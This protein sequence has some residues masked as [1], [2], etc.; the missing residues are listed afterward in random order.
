M[1]VPGVNLICAATFLAA[2]GEHPP[3]HDQPQAGRLSRAWIRRSASP[4]RRRHAPGGSPSAGRRTRGGRWS[5]RRGAWSGNPGRCTRSTSGPARGA[6]TARRSSRPPASSRSCS[7]ACSPAARTTP[8]SS[9][10]LTKKKLREL[11]LTAGAEAARPRPPPGSGRPTG[12]PRR[13]ARTRRASRGRPTS[14]WSTTSRPER[15][16]E[17]WAR[18][19]HRSAHKLGPR[20]AKLRGRLKAPDVC[21]SLRQS[22]APTDNLTRHDNADNPGDDHLLRKYRPQPR[23]SRPTRRTELTG[24]DLTPSA[25]LP[26]RYRRPES[27]FKVRRNALDFLTER[28]P[29]AATS[30]P[31]GWFSGWRRADSLT[32]CRPVV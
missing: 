25:T 26:D 15:R 21:A 30:D 3:V 4:A 29:W 16:R 14:G 2:I 32:F 13:R 17:K 12:D 31:F 22:P 28:F 27:T 11:E 6:V 23:Q 18:A 10:S 1:T 20:R 24:A 7:G 8:T 5:K 9:P 19:R